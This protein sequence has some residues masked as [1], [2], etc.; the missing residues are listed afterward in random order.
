MNVQIAAF[1]KQIGGLIDVIDGFRKTIQLLDIYRSEAFFSYEFT[2]IR[3]FLNDITDTRLRSDFF[4]CRGKQFY[5]VL[6]KTF[7]D[8]TIKYL[9]IYI[10]VVDADPVDWYLDVSYEICLLNQLP[11]GENR[12]RRKT[13]QRIMSDK[14][15][16]MN[17]GNGKNDF[18]TPTDLMEQ[19]FLK[20]DKIVVQI[21]LKSG[22]LNRNC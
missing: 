16:G 7:A 1:S 18:I 6:R 13:D 4:H 11:G 20:N 8:Q 19:G 10:Y 12:A 5:I 15:S 2:N 14:R 9:G 17:P 21:K 22:R 3:A